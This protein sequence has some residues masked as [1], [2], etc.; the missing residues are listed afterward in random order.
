VKHGQ[1]IPKDKRDDMA[2]I[3][4]GI[5]LMCPQRAE[6]I[7]IVAGMFDVSTTT[8]RNL[9]CGGRFLCGAKLVRKSA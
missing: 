7:E 2:R 5:A 9:L 1:H 8:A 3:A 4:H 6:A